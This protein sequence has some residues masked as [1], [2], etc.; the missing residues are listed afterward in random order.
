MT[1]DQATF[2][3]VRLQTALHALQEALRAMPALNG[4]TMTESAHQ[5]TEEIEESLLEALQA[6]ETAQAALKN[7]IGV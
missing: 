5:T 2:V 7:I 3:Y 4:D 6:A 1:K